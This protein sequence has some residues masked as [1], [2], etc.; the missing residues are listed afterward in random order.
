MR[1]EKGSI[2]QVHNTTPNSLIQ[3]IEKKIEIRFNDFEKKLQL[4][5]ESVKWYTRF[6][7]AKILSVSLVTLNAWAKNGILPCHKIG[8]RV[9][10][11][12]EDIEKALIKIK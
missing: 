9:R 7:T 3:A 11:K 8:N 2:T 4:K 12:S 1:T 6:E 10:Y 5:N